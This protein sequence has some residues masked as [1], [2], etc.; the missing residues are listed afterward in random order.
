MITPKWH[1]FYT[2]N[3]KN[4]TMFSS[5][6]KSSGYGVR[7]I[8]EQRPYMDI[9]A[10]SA[11]ALDGSRSALTELCTLLPQSSIQSMHDLG[12]D[13]RV[14]VIYNR[15]KPKQ[16]ARVADRILFL[17]GLQ[18]PTGVYAHGTGHLGV[19]KQALTQRSQVV[20]AIGSAQQ[21]LMES[22]P[23]TAGERI[24]LLRYALQANGVDASRFFTIPVRDIAAN[25]GFASKVIAMT[26]AFNAAI[27]G[28]D[29]TKRLFGRGDYEMISLTRQSSHGSNKPLSGTGVRNDWMAVDRSLIAKG[30]PFDDNA[31]PAISK[32]LEHRLDPAIMDKMR[33]IDGYGLM[34]FLAYAK[35]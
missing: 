26:P 12:I 28:N 14:S 25:A 34:H 4:A 20:I 17:G 6:E 22:D 23:F 16:N 8:E 1:S 31:I 13:D 7:L 10:L 15:E 21:S 35:E 27:A 2:S 33:V 29:W 24:D 9:Y 32:E 30:Q 11:K 5:F 3:F 18:P 19:I